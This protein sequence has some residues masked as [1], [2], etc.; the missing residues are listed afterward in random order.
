MV[1]QIP[2]RDFFRNPEKVAFKISPDGSHIS[3]MAP[4]QHR[5]N[6]FVQPVTGRGEPTRITA[7]TDRNIAGYF[8]ANNQTLLYF[9]DNG[10]DENF[11]LFTVNTDG[12]GN[13]DITPFGD[14]VARLVDEL[15]ENNDEVLIALNKRQPELFDVYRFNVNTGQLLM[16]AENPGNIAEWLTDHEGKIRVAVASDGVNHQLLY[17]DTEDQPFRTI[18][19]TNFRQTLSPQLFTPDNRFVY[20]VSNIGRDKSAL[21]VFDIANGK[22]LEE[23]YAHPE[24]DVASVI[25]SY[26]QKKLLGASFI[27]WTT[28]F[29][30]FDHGRRQLQQTLEQ[31]LQRKVYVVDKDKEEQNF[32]VAATGDRTYGTYYLYNTTTG[33]LQKLADISPWLN[34]ND[35]CEMKPITYTSRDGLTIH[36]YLT[37]PKGI[38]PKNLPVVVNPHGGPWHRDVWGFNPEVQFLA[39]RGFAVL[40]MNFRGST[41]YGRAFW[42]ASFK[43]WGKTMQNDI[44]DGVHWLIDQG[45]ADPERVAI[46]GGS[47]GGYAVLA[48]LTFTPHLY[49]CGIDFVG[50]SNLFTFLNTI[51]P[52][53]K[54]FLDMMYEMVGH[55]E[56]D[57][58][59]LT[60][61]SPVFHVQQIIAPL[62]V[63]QGAKDPRVNINESDQ[64][65]N[66]LRNNG[67]EVQYMVKENEGHGFHNQE[68]KF[69]FYEAMEQFLEEHLHPANVT[70]PVTG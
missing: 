41:G 60:E 45:I 5:M 7:E 12:T 68:N 19:T 11:H 6:I 36:G 24:V 49:A 13:R 23:I 50:V 20:A 58:Q 4:Y 42:E 54:P 9:K 15:P 61:A 43:Q 67:V 32:I 21:V 52:Y 2:L 62:F 31:L 27:T 34:E 3:F 39:N 35:L 17:R 18:M 8:W 55:P 22:E 69:E 65:V 47:Y 66:A 48:G 56:K 14:V 44:T 16:A 57:K 1:N 25:Y 59:H 64:I 28:E 10:G 30:F 51:P 37:L 63:A 38:E 29:A 33:N 46:Y 40:Q 70:E 26:K 53:W